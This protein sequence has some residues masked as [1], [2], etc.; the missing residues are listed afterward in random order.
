MMKPSRKQLDA[1]V[2]IAR[3]DKYS[4]SHLPAPAAGRAAECDVRLMRAATFSN[5]SPLFSRPCLFSFSRVFAHA[6]LFDII[7]HFSTSA[8][9]M[10]KIAPL[11]MPLRFKGAR[12]HPFLSSSSQSLIFAVEHSTRRNVYYGNTI[13]WPRTYYLCKVNNSSLS[14]LLV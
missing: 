10:K 2:K 14:P 3:K 9:E 13:L 12:A 6:L 7:P 4:G 1:A 8:G 5:P 11:K